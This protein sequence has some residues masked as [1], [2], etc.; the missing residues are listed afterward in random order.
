[1]IVR[2]R[3]RDFIM[4]RQNDHALLSGDLARHWKEAYLPAA[5]RRNDVVL[6]VAEHDRGW[7]GLDDTPVWDDAEN[8]PCGFIRYPLLPKL[9]FYRKG[10]DEAEEMSPYAAILCSM[11][12]SSFFRNASQPAALR[13]VEAEKKRRDRLERYCGIRDAEERSRLQEHLRILQFCDDLSLFVCLNEPGAGKDRL[14]P[15]YREGFP[16]SRDL[17]FMQGNRI[18]ARWEGKSTVIVTPF[19]FAEE[20]RGT[21]LYKTVDK[22]LIRMYGI[23]RAYRDTLQEELAV[24]FR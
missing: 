24:V 10:I 6:A 14:H 15:W 1:M 22:S 8:A 17:A 11:H 4:I 23:D 18:I 9:A 5:E 21:L 12:Y 20:V 2:E 19:P 13:F 3:E 7:I 16:D